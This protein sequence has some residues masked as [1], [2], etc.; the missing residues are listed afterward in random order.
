MAHQ[1]HGVICGMLGRLDEAISH[2]STAER[3]MPDSYMSWITKMWQSRTLFQ[4]GRWAE[5]DAAIDSAI[6]LN[7]T[8]ANS[9]LMRALVGVRLGRDHEAHVDVRKARQLGLDLSQA[10]HLFRLVFPV[11]PTLDTDIATIR[12]LYAVTDVGA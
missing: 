12:D 11:S 10:L 5:A 7:P 9:H 8:W 6:A 2:L 4:A 1:T 3:L